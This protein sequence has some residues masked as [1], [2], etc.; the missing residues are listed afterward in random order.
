L[1]TAATPKAALGVG[2]GSFVVQ[3]FSVLAPETGTAKIVE[4]AVRK[5]RT[6]A[7]ALLIA[8]TSLLGGF[9]IKDF[10]YKALD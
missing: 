9:A 8:T 6:S 1:F 7:K 2:I 10:S 3:V 5:T 4:D